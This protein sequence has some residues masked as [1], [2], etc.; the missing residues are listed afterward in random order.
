[1]RSEPV[2]ARVITFSSLVF[3]SK[4]FCLEDDPVA[5]PPVGCPLFLEGDLK[6]EW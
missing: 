3:S 6:R 5:R 1:V 4:I 2:K